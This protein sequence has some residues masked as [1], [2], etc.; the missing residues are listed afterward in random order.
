MATFKSALEEALGF[1]KGVAQGAKS[2]VSSGVSNLTSDYSNWTRRREEEERKRRQS[3]SRFLSDAKD[4]FKPESKVSFW[5]TPTAQ[6]LGDIQTTISKTRPVQDISQAGKALTANIRSAADI[7]RAG[8]KQYFTPELAEQGPSFWK[9]RMAQDLVKLQTETP[10]KYVSKYGPYIDEQLKLAT[11]G[12]AAMT[13]RSVSDIMRG[14]GMGKVLQYATPAYYFNSPEE[15]EQYARVYD[16]WAKGLSTSALED[17]QKVEDFL[18]QNAIEAD[19]PEWGL[20]QKFSDPE[21]V[22]RGLLLN[23]PSLFFNLAAAVGTFLVTKNPVLA[24]NAAL[25]TAF[26]LEGGTSYTDALADNVPEPTARTIGIGVG[27]VNAYLERAFPMAKLDDLTRAAVQKSIQQHAYEFVK[28]A[29]FREGVQESIQEIVSNVGKAVYDENYRSLAGLMAGVP[30]AGIFGT[31]LGGFANVGMAPFQGSMANITP[32][33]TT[34]AEEERPEE[35]FRVEPQVAPEEISRSVGITPAT[36]NPA[37]TGTVYFDLTNQYNQAWTA[38]NYQQAATVRQQLLE[39]GRNDLVNAF[40]D[41]LDIKLD[42]SLSHSTYFG[43]SEPTL[44]VKATMPK[45]SEAEFIKRI[46]NVAE[47]WGQRTVHF[48]ETF[49]AL[50]ESQVYGKELP[51]GF[52]FEPE[53]N[54]RFSRPL[55][56][57]EQRIISDKIQSLGLAGS[58]FHS[59][60]SGVLLYNISK[61]KD[62]EQFIIEANQIEEAIRGLYTKRD[63]SLSQEIQPEITVAWAARRLL[64]GGS[65][66][67]GATRDY[68]QLRSFVPPTEGYRVQVEESPYNLETSEVL[69]TLGQFFDEGEIAFMANDPGTIVTSTGEIAA[70]KYTSALIQAVEQDGK[71]QDQTVYHEAFHAYVDMFAD[72]KLHQDALKQIKE[73]LSIKEDKAGE[74]ALAENFATWM[75]NKQTGVAGKIQQ[76][77]DWLWNNLKG[78]IGKRNQ[79]QTIYQ[80]ML[81]KKRARGVRSGQFAL[82]YRDAP[83]VSVMGVHQPNLT[84]KII[85]SLINEVKGG[86]EGVTSVQHIE[87]LTNRGGLKQAERDLARNIANR[88]AVDGKVNVAE[89]AK[90]YRRNLLPLEAGTETSW[91]NIVLPDEVRGGVYDYRERIYSSPFPTE[92]GRHFRNFP[93]YFAHV[94]VEDMDDMSEFT[95]DLHPY[96]A[97]TGGTRR[98]IEIQSD[99]FQIPTEDFERQF[100]S[101]ESLNRFYELVTSSELDSIEGIK[102]ATK[103][104]KDIVKETFLDK[105]HAGKIQGY[106]DE[107]ERRITYSEGQIADWQKE[108]E[109]F[110]RNLEDKTLTQEKRE[111]YQTYIRMDEENIAK[112]EEYIPE[113]QERNKF[114]QKVISLLPDPP[115]EGVTME[116]LIRPYRNVWFE[117]IFKEEIAKAATDGKDK[118]QIPTGETISRIEGYVGSGVVPQDAVPGDTFEYGGEDWTVLEDFGDTVTAVSSYEIDNEFN[119]ETAVDEEIENGFQDR[120]VYEFDHLSADSVVDMDL[121]RMINSVLPVGEMTKYRENP[122][123]YIKNNRQDLEEKLREV[124]DEDLRKEYPTPLA[125]AQKWSDDTGQSYYAVGDEIIVLRPDAYTEQLSKG[126][127]EDFDAANLTEEQQT[128]YDRYQEEYPKFLRKL[129]PDLKEVEDEQG[130]SWWETKITDKDKKAVEAFRVEKKAPKIEES[131]E[132][133]EDFWLAM[134]NLRK[135]RG[136]HVDMFKTPTEMTEEE[137]GMEALAKY[138]GYQPVAPETIERIAP[139]AME[140]INHLNDVRAEFVKQIGDIE[141]ASRNYDFYTKRFGK[142]MYKKELTTLKKELANLVKGIDKEIKG[143]QTETIAVEKPAPTNEELAMQALEKNRETRLIQGE[144]VAPPPAVPPAEPPRNAPPPA[145]PE[146]PEGFT[147]EAQKE[148]QTDFRNKAKVEGLP[149]DLTSRNDKDKFNTILSWMIGQHDVAQIT[150]TELAEQL[151]DIP[152]EKGMDVIRAVEAGGSEDPVINEHVQRIKVLFD[153][154][155]QV[156]KDTPEID[157]GYLE[158]YITHIWEG[159]MEDVASAYRQWKTKFRFANE[160]IIPTYEEGIAMGLKPKFTHPAPII[161]Q[162]AGKLYQTIANIEAFKS[163][164]ETG[165]LVPYPQARKLPGYMPVVAPGIR[166][167]YS[168]DTT[169]GDKRMVAGDY[170]APKTIAATLNKVF[171]PQEPTGA[172]EKGMSAIA[173]VSSAMQDLGLSGGI[174]YTPLNAWTFGQ[175]YRETV[176][177]IGGLLTSPL[178]SIKRMTSLVGSTLRPLIP[179]Q[180]T[181]FFKNNLG[182]IKKMV[183]RNIPLRHTYTLEDL[184][185]PSFKNKFVGKGFRGTWQ[186]AIFDATFR[187]F[188]PLVQISMFNEIEKAALHK[189]YTSTQAAD[190][191]A[192]A[193]KK[194]Y[195]IVD[196]KDRALRSKVMNDVLTTF[197]FAPHYR[198]TMVRSWLNTLTSTLPV[199]VEGGKIRLNNPLSL[200]NRTNFNLML[201]SIFVLA[202]YNMLNYALT[203]RRLKE[204]PPETKDK[205]LIPLNDGY[206]L[207]IPLFPSTG[208]VVRYGLGFLDAARQWDTQEMAETG[209]NLLSFMIRPVFDAATNSDYFGRKI[210][211]DDDTPEVRRKKSAIYIALQYNH[212]WIEALFHST[213]ANVW[214]VEYKKR[215]DYQNMLEALEAPTRFYESK[216]LQ[217]RYF[218]EN[219]KEV[220]GTLSSEDQAIWDKLHKQGGYFFDE[221]DGLVVYDKR[222]AMANALDRLAHPDIVRAE[223]EAAIK[224]A[225]EQGT[226]IAPFYTLTPDQQ[227]G[228]LLLKTFYPGDPQYKVERDKRMDWLPE[229]WDKTKQWQQEMI[230]LG[231]FEDKAQGENA[232][233]R[234]E[235]VQKLFLHGTYDSVQIAKI[236]NETE[237]GGWTVEEVNSHMTNQNFL[238]PNPDLQAKLDYFNTLPKGTGARSR[239]VNAN[240][241]VKAYFEATAAKTEMARAELG[242][243]PTEGYGGFAPYEKQISL[244]IPSLEQ[245]KQARIKLGVSDI[246]PLKLRALTTGI[247]DIPASVIPNRYGA[248]LKLPSLSEIA[249]PKA[250]MPMTISQLG[251]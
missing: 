46:S 20:K 63:G 185:N 113:L 104:T 167:A 224:S 219:L 57:T 53:K 170:Y 123:T 159:K 40:A 31:L 52:T 180:S 243:S 19:N 214:G 221:D 209:K 205:L 69:N 65:E 158:N 83:G 220:R 176:A 99:L 166:R 42:V 191:A 210:F 181:K 190:V 111:E 127:V 1:V 94:R 153:Q 45:E 98:L 67:D 139:E 82:S 130:I 150:A 61:F 129:R 115:A 14:Q 206:T 178:Y 177:N 211:A 27:I 237:G 138:R 114:Y 168:V 194:F 43:E 62:Y 87:N 108:L 227:F 79:V 102:N 133:T 213:N 232:Q 59:D 120:I 223:T 71:V 85:Q 68:S 202:A 228:V 109:V 103:R 231:V 179:G 3:V 131:I 112:R 100:V 233:K 39:Q 193:V 182:Q 161:A 10:I 13:L 183:A 116:K 147:E 78:L 144:A 155:Y 208:T 88:L 33:E 74:E 137:L 162:Y 2:A 149:A 248:S 29:V 48:S 151:L 250:T 128:I 38:G 186:K 4:Y 35:Q 230:R 12:T 222:S 216:S 136:F 92:M 246:A 93:N 17:K 60:N 86:E 199:R 23:A 141:D 119:W 251:R 201:G 241:D 148:T 55:T 11:K 107:G 47:T 122:V 24:G 157:I 247:P 41:T 249:L 188:M 50:P 192:D 34:V 169:T 117:R 28:D 110:K 36:T 90:E 242:L 226:P 125:F 89:F 25:G 97:K 145:P 174:P 121:S 44:I 84:S 173:Q 163:M 58:T 240:P 184:M 49:S 22:A 16:Y 156:A 146:G 106:I 218:Y 175:L 15:R 126:M 203:G 124:I 77:F 244:K 204:N 70:G 171:S 7:V 26:V 235:S 207:G 76:F 9:S 64:V 197:F 30:E 80:E 172:F 37:M 72:E 217:S 54:I 132:N 187:K 245:A 21:F 212:P 225:Q 198:E 51:S 5:T 234:M 73:E 164:R 196:T 135:F 66:E 32:V 91:E 140:R 75:Q 81:A 8:P 101:P 160:R 152:E 134:R 6:R 229:Y 143:L 215:P 195:G 239:Y 118:I 56:N 95:D 189:G 154:L 96:G 200:E 238:E 236:L 18:Q 142:L 105:R 165:L